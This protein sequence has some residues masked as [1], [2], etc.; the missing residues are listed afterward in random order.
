MT[1]RENKFGIKC[2]FMYPAFKIQDPATQAELQL[3]ASVEFFPG[4]F[5]PEFVDV[6]NEIRQKIERQKMAVEAAS[7]APVDLFN[8]FELEGLKI[9][10]DVIN[11]S[12][13]FP[14]SVAAEDGDFSGEASGKK[15]RAEMPAKKER[16]TAPGDEE[17]DENDE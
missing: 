9:K 13:F 11:N 2:L 15:K 12:T 4:D 8:E 1:K 7:D 14:V 17:E 10:V 5:L 16:R 6:Q 3:K